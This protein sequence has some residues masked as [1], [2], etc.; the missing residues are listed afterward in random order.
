MPWNIRVFQIKA[1]STWTE[2]HTWVQCD[3]VFYAILI[4]D[5]IDIFV[6][7]FSIKYL[8]PCKLLVLSSWAS[9][10]TSSALTP[11]KCAVWFYSTCKPSTGCSHSVPRFHSTIWFVLP[12]TVLLHYW[13][14]TRVTLF[15]SAGGI[16]SSSLL[17]RD[18]S[19]IIYFLANTCMALLVYVWL[20]M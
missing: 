12:F 13:L 1:C 9:T 3:L 16:S 19:L 14:L 18:S 6:V 4:I 20:N 17:S 5:F 15:N 8:I 11:G 2:N 10:D 7:R